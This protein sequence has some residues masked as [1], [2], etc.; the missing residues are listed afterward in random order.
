MARPDYHKDAPVP[1]RV[2]PDLLAWIDEQER[3][4]SAVIIEAIRE[5]RDR[6]TAG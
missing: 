2:P 3:S 4:R 5:K 6:E 1:V